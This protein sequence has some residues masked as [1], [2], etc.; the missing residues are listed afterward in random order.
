LT[1]AASLTTALDRGPACP[2]RLLSTVAVSVT[3]SGV[4]AASVYLVLASWF[5]AWSFAFSS[6]DEELPYG[7]R[8]GILIAFNLVVALIV[9]L[10][11]LWLI[12]L[13]GRR[14]EISWIAAVFLT[15]VIL[16]FTARWFV[17]ALTEV[18]SCVTGI[19]FPLDR[20]RCDFG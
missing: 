1:A 2:R 7:L 3:A 15:A 20:E 9:V 16:G 4:T 13:G 12:H 11:P 10:L 18:N 6:L 17:G 8:L 14:L 19:A 5:I